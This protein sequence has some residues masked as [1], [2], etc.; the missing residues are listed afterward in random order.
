MKP[1]RSIL[2]VGIALAVL[3]TSASAETFPIFADTVGSA[4]TNTI[5]K[6]AGAAKTLVISGKSTAFINFSVSSSGIDPAKVTAARLVIFAPKAST[7]GKLTIKT[8][9]SGFDEVFATTER[10]K[11]GS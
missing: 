8:L 9:T 2:T 5:A 6:P 1:F 4:T 7:T 11:T 3:S 10:S